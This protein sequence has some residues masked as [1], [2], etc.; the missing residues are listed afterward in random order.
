[1]SD[2]NRVY[3]LPKETIEDLAYLAYGAELSSFDIDNLLP[4]GL[5]TEEV[6]SIGIQVQNTVETVM[7]SRDGLANGMRAEFRSLYALGLLATT[8]GDLITAGSC[9]R[10]LQ[11]RI[12]AK[13]HLEGFGYI[14][15]LRREIRKLGTA[16]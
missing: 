16:I 2:N 15:I 8:R 1:M 7:P 10:H 3:I 6:D 14:W 9:S 11:S 4:K 13:P 5:S 12:K